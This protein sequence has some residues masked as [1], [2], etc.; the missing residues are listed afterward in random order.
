LSV[1]VFFRADYGIVESTQEP[2][3]LPRTVVSVIRVD[4]FLLLAWLV[5]TVG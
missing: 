1:D 2:T 3:A 5:E 4:S